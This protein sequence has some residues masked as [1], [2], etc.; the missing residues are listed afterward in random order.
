[1]EGRAN[2]GR[3]LALRA[4]VALYL[5]CQVARSTKPPAKGGSRPIRVAIAPPDKVGEVE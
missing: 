3:P 1:M 4:T 5:A 2:L